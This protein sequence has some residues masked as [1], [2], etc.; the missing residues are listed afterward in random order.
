VVI[1]SV[2]WS[3]KGAIF[4]AVAVDSGVRHRVVADH[5]VMPRE[6]VPGEV[7][8]IVGATKHHLRYGDQVEVSKATLLRPSGRLVVGAIARSPLFRGIGEVRAKRLW[9]AF[10][11]EL[12]ALLDSGDPEPFVEV[13]GEDLART[14]VEGWAEMEAETSIYRWLD[15]HGVNAGLARSIT[16]VFGRNAIEALEENPYRLLAFSTWNKVDALARSMGIS[17]G[18]E[19]RRVAAADAVVYQ[20]LQ[21]SHTVCEEKAFI[22]LLRKALGCDVPGSKEALHAALTAHGII[23]AGQGIQGL[24]PASMEQFIAQRVAEMTSLRFEAA[25]GRLR[26]PVDVVRIADEFKRL[27]GINLNAEQ[28][29]AVEMAATEPMCCIVGGAGVGKTTVLKAVHMAVERSGGAIVQM[30]LAGRAALRMREA[31]KRPAM[32]IARFLK[33]VDEGRLTLDQCQ[34]VVVDES[35]MVD[36]PTLYRVLRRMEAGCRLVLVGDSAQLPPIGFGLCFHALAKTD[37]IPRVELAEIHRAA[38][39]TGIPQASVTIREG[40]VP[41]LPAYSGL[42]PGVTF[43]D[44]AP[45]DVAGSVLDV[46]NDLGGVFSA[47]IITA[48]KAGK[49][50]T[51]PINSMFHMLLTPGRLSNGG[52]A[53]GEPVIWTVNNYELGLMNG[54][55]GTVVSAVDP[56]VLVV[57]WD[58]VKIPIPFESWRDMEHAYAITCHKAQGSQF[59]RVIVPVLPSRLLDRTLLYTAVTRAQQQVVLIGNRQAFEAAIIGTPNP[60]RRE[61]GMEHHLAEARERA[62]D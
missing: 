31:T 24:G 55:L 27:E 14:L 50:G 23:R 9:E 25:Q 58:G 46:V 32:T 15:S 57:D 29:L 45:D 48:T 52:F 26:V 22:V 47:Q 10:N 62:G 41:N 34:T 59:H 56:E 42:R 33:E 53:E 13:L 6:P 3:G 60:S 37:S 39:E 36:L 43:I 19:R 54:S 4:N 2:L 16:T 28:R 1:H 21:F 61:S 7:W 20:R 17:V 51:R 12:Y 11:E 5:L 40:F 44:A 38:A 49:A 8:D 35:S 18:D 30:A